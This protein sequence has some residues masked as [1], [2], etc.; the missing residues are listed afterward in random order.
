MLNINVNDAQRL[1]VALRTEMKRLKFLW[2]FS[3]PCPLPF[4]VTKIKTR[5]ILKKK[6]FKTGAVCAERTSWWLRVSFKHLTSTSLTHTPTY[7]L[8][9]NY[10]CYI[11]IPLHFYWEHRWECG[12]LECYTER[13]C[14]YRSSTERR[15]YLGELDRILNMDVTRTLEGVPFLSQSLSSAREA[16]GVPTG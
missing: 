4:G 5:I 13:G 1:E 15:G 7:D 14:L 16:Q 10:I 3:A 8:A 9:S 2:V 6:R 12:V 11:C